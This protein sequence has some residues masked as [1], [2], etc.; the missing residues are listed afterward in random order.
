MDDERVE[1]GREVA[2]GAD[3]GEK[4]TAEGFTSAGARHN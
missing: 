3:A 4:K 1:V 2:T